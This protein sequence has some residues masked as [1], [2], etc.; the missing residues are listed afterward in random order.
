MKARH[1]RGFRGCDLLC[2]GSRLTQQCCLM[3]QF[4]LVDPI[5]VDSSVEVSEHSLTTL[6]RSNNDATASCCAMAQ[7]QGRALLPGSALFEAALAA[8]HSA[9]ANDGLLPTAL[10]LT[11]RSASVAAPLVLQEQGRPQPRLVC[12]L[13]MRYRC[14]TLD[15]EA[16]CTHA[17]QT[18]CH[19]LMQQHERHST[20]RPVTNI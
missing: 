2:T 1:L 9:R 13:A 8:G 10:G 7:V 20:P 11:I 3:Q 12:S 18:S 15:P 16:Q 14:R 17:Q 19:A 6:I 5:A 4:R